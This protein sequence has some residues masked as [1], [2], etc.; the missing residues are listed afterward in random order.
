M[1]STYKIISS[2]SHVI[3]P[4][5]LWQERLPAKFRDRAP[6]LLHDEAGDKLVCEDVEMPPIGTAA[7]VFRKDTEVRQTGRWEDDVPASAYDPV[8]RLAEIDRDGVWGEVLYPTFGLGFY[9]IED[10]EFKW[11]LLRAYNDWLAEFCQSNPKR[12]K[13]IAMVANDDP[14]LAAEE[15]ERAAKLGMPGVMIPTVAGEGVPQYHERGMDRL[16]AAA[17]ANNMSVNVHS[18]TTRDRNKKKTGLQVSGGRNPTRSPQGSRLIVEVMLNMIF[19]GVFERFP[20][21]TFVSAENEAGWAPHMLARADYEW[22]R[23]ANVQVKDFEGRIPLAPSDYFRRNIKLTFMR[24]IVAI[25][26]HDL[27]GTETLMYQTDFPHGVST[28]PNTRQMADEMFAGLSDDARDKI[29]CKTAE[30]LYQF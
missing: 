3:E 29:V 9:G 5:F 25:R 15:V 30:T 22:K 23:Y 13:G 10:T 16:W 19:G 7:G 11:A 27:L 28:Y 6:R 1:T 8:A 17:V 2:D 21:M 4:W 26:C 20:E 12:Y 14:Q 24:D 18:G